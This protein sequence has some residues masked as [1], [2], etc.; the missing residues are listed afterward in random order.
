MTLRRVVFSDPVEGFITDAVTGDQ[1]DA[2]SQLISNVADPV[3][4]QDVATKAYVDALIDGVS[5]KQPVKAATI[6]TLGQAS[7]VDGV[8]TSAADGALGPIDGV[9]LDA[10]DRLLVKMGTGNT[11]PSFGLD[12]PYNGIYVV[13]DLGSPS[14]PWVFTRA[15]DADT[16]EKIRGAAVFVMEGTVYAESAYVLVADAPITLGTSSLRFSPFAS[17]TP[18]S[19]DQGLAKSGN[20]V[21][22][23]LD[24]SADAQG[25][26]AGGGSSG[27]E[28]DADVASGKLRVAVKSDGGVERSASGLA[29]KLD[30]TSLSTSATGLKVMS[31]PAIADNYVANEAIA[32]GDPVA[33][34]STSGR[35]LK[36]RSDNNAKAR[37]I[38]IAATA[39]ASAGD[40]LA[41]VN[42]GILAGA[43]SGATPNTPYFLQSAGGIDTTPPSGSRSIC[44]GTAL[45]A[46]DLWVDIVD[47]GARAVGGAPPSPT[48]LNF[49]VTD[50]GAW[51]YNGDASSQS[52][53][54]SLLTALGQNSTVVL[55][56][57]FNLDTYVEINFTISATNAESG[58]AADAYYA[59]ILDSAQPATTL[60]SPAFVG[61]AGFWGV[62]FN[63]YP[64]VVP[65]SVL[66][67]VDGSAEGSRTNLTTQTDS[68]STYFSYKLTY[69]TIAG[70]CTMALKQGGIDIFTRTISAPPS[71]SS[72]RLAFGG[73]SGGVGS[74]T[75]VGD[76]VNV[77]TSSVAPALPTV[78][79][80][81]ATDTGA[82]QYNGDAAAQSGYGS[83]ITTSGQ[84]SSIIYKSPIT[85]QSALEIDFTISATSSTYLGPA[86]AYFAG[87]LDSAYPDTSLGYGNPGFW[88]LAFNLYP[89][90]GTPQSAIPVENGSSTGTRVNFTTQTNA[91]WL[92]TTYKLV[93]TTTGGSCSM[94][95]MKDG[96]LLHQWTL[97]S[98]P[99]FA[100]G[101]LCFLAWSG[102][103]GADVRVGDS[104]TAIITP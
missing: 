83:L 10:G 75:R 5:W 51:Q 20:L 47:R 41:V 101:R 94:T 37:V 66:T 57:S 89:Y 2:S 8:I 56:N 78:L 73:W 87:I 79:N 22:V 33:I 40:T 52:G 71:F 98:C 44:V 50:T 103:A 35:V 93:I 88:G 85:L 23:D 1:I 90:G 70:V 76:A 55:K 67:L 14:T 3:S 29:L 15:A 27:L 97:S 65:Q 30:G 11:P 42:R 19:F 38:G 39:A 46:S 48:V 43:L 28:F 31:T 49:T 45:S 16:A 81:S 68:S 12:S 82:W 80:L 60:G 58:N 13:T 64:G 36:A 34:S 104:V 69:T 24:T 17:T 9:T 86:D 21:K 100:S 18:Y 62:E 53:Y 96:S 25:A 92:Y 102:G 26:G 77:V 4:V 95:L 72:A 54:G 99:S 7:Y 59:G 91:T 84:S 32:I 61:Q 63:L 74:N 6:F